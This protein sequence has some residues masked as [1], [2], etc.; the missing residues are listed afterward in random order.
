MCDIF[1]HAAGLG[2]LV[3]AASGVI[4]KSR[5]REGLVEEQPGPN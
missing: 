1:L 5:S 4:A 2:L 3:R